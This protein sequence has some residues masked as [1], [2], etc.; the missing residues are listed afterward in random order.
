[1]RGGDF[2]LCDGSDVKLSRHAR[3]RC[4]ERHIN[5]FYVE[6]SHAIIRNRVVVTAWQKEPKNFGTR[7][8]KGVDY[9]RKTHKAVCVPKDVLVHLPKYAA[10]QERRERDQLQKKR[11]IKRQRKKKPKEPRSKA[12]PKARRKKKRSRPPSKH[13]AKA[14]PSL[15]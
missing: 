6:N 5:P 3:R 11:S 9:M 7:S 1:M 14:Y 2:S 15:H 12:V 13:T 10:R 4:K 8:S